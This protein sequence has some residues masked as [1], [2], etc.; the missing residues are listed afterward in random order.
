VIWTK[1]P[2]GYELGLS[3]GRILCR[4]KAGTVLA[5]VPSALKADPTLIELTHAQ[6]WLARHEAHCLAEVERWMVGSLPVPVA[7]LVQV[8]PDPSWQRALKDLV[9]RSQPTPGT[10]EIGLLH[11]V[12][13]ERG[14]EIVTPDH[15]NRWSD[16]T[17]VSIPHPALLPDLAGLRDFVTGLGAEQAVQQVLRKVYRPPGDI[18]LNVSGVHDWSGGRFA[19]L[20]HLTG[21]ASSHGYAV[22]GGFAAQK[23]F[24]ADRTIEAR[25]WLGSHAP[26]AEAETGSLTW[27]DNQNQMLSLG[28]VG[29]VSWSEGARMAADLYAGRVVD[30]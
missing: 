17:F 21:R 28:E 20:R 11:A 16:V 13:A 29:A 12:D 27:C 30:E 18:R 6:Q 2:S 10:A 8:W 19:Q 24:E 1:T 22:R 4:N 3:D 23:I 26:G 14:V 25:V 5:A 15:V 7:A 9:V